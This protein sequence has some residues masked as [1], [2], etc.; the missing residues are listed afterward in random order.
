MNGT[1]RINDIPLDQGTFGQVQF[2]NWSLDSRPNPWWNRDE[3]LNY[4][5]MKN[6]CPAP[7]DQLMPSFFQPP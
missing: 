1:G 2:K 6:C 4:S 5:N 7:T 3:F